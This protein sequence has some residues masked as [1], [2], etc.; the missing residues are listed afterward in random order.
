[1]RAPSIR[2]R[3]LWSLLTAVGGLWVVASI[4]SYVDAHREIDRL[5]DAHL[6]Q[7]AQLLSRQAGHELLEM[8]DL[9]PEELQP[10]AQQFAVQL[11]D[12]HGRLALRMGPAPAS[13]FSSVERGF[14]DA[15]VD[16][17][18][19][20]VFSDW[21]AEHG[22]LVQM[23]ERHDARRRLA[24][25]VALNGLLPL[26]IALPI[27]GVLIWRLVAGGLGP[28]RR[29]ADEVAQRDPGNLDSL[30]DSA[31][32]AEIQPLVARLNA[33]FQRIRRSIESERRFTSDAAH[34]LRNPVAAIRAQAEASLASNDPA[35]ARAGLSSIE[36]SASRLS[37]LVDQLLALAR[38]DARAEGVPLAEIDL[39]RVARQTLAELAPGVFARGGSID[40]EAPDSALIPGDATLL[41][42]VIRNLVDNALVHGGAGV[43][44]ATAITVREDS[45]ELCIADDG[46]G[47]PE[48]LRE[49]L[50]QRF[51]RAQRGH[52]HGSGLGLSIVA[53][54]L[55]LHGAS[56]RY[57]SG[58]HGRGL[59]VRI[60]FPS[61]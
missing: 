29:I 15:V 59:E 34:E 10:Y 19:W 35:K 55:E 51:L 40:L 42:V 31:A 27:M 1:M 16:G 8:D 43:H 47:V 5:L 41:E 17:E 24:M 13:R 56:I 18:Q 20:R 58:K 11:W 53:R 49:R 44:I 39:V 61:S 30:E 48:E 26:L 37:R 32:P 38:L 6:A 9:E 4:A 14:S 60:T 3:L 52:S 25:K 28:I 22:I 36:Q 12:E 23:A 50:G 45:I 54:I 33:L 2:N 57:E 46:P 7:S 21:D